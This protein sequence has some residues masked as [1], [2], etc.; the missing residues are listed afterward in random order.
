MK[1]VALVVITSAEC[2]SEVK[3]LAKEA[4]AVGATIIDAKGSGIEEKKSFF[5][6]TFEGNQSVLLYVLEAGLGRKVLRA[7][8]QYFDNPENDGL[9]FTTPM[10][11]IVGLDKKLLHKFE[12]NIEQEERL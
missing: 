11:F 5:S 7:L 2:E 9:A 4:G 12:T 3:A 8:K 6:L 10:N 1:F